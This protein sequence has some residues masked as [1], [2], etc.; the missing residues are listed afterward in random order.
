L[1]DE[2][3]SHADNA[4][5]TGIEFPIA[6]VEITMRVAGSSL[7]LGPRATTLPGQNVITGGWIRGGQVGIQIGDP[8]RAGS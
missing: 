7:D 5:R 1:D 6:V 8:E 2:P 3:R 4:A